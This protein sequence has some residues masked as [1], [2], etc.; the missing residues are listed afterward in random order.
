MGATV[1]KC[2]PSATT[3]TLPQQSQKRSQESSERAAAER[4]AYGK[5]AVPPTK[6]HES[7][8]S[9]TTMIQDIQKGLDK[10]NNGKESSR[11]EKQPVV[12]PRSLQ[13]EFEDLQA[14]VD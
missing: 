11:F 5:K 6:R 8:D 13:E 14:R 12:T 4:E 7:Q 3:A 1:G 9:L 2:A 10:L